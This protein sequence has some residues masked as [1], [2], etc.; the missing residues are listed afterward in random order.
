VDDCRPNPA[1][2]IKFQKSRTAPAQL[3]PGGEKPE[4]HH[5]EQ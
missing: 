2:E 3:K 4:R 1:K 5:V